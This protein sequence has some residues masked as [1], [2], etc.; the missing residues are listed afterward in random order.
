MKVT[1]FDVKSPQKYPKNFLG[2]QIGCSGDR[3]KRAWLLCLGQ[4]PFPLK[5]FG[6]LR[7]NVNDVIRYPTIPGKGSSGPELSG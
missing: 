7:Q 6:V 5:V 2:E 4:S 1:F 3:P